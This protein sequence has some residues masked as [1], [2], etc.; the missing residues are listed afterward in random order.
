MSRIVVDASVI[1]PIVIPDE[2]G[3]LIPEVFGAISAG[4]AVVPQHWRL[5]VAN[6]ARMAVRRGR[7]TEEALSSVFSDLLDLAIE[8]D[9]ETDRHAW[10]TALGLSRRHDLTAYDAAYLELALRLQLPL[11]T[12]DGKLRRAALAE[13]AQLVGPE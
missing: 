8:V 10:T 1:G 2:A 6:L 9:G 4:D 3:D 13:G 5:E 11:A 12:S 7:L